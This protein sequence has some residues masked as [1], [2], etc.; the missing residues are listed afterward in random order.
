MTYRQHIYQLAREHNVEVREHASRLD[1][2]YAQTELRYLYVPP[3][4]SQLTYMAALH[5]LGHLASGH[6]GSAILPPRDILRQEGEAWQ[7]ALAHTMTRRI[8]P[9]VARRM[10]G[11]LRTYERAFRVPLEPAAYAESA[12]ALTRL[13]NGTPDPE[14]QLSL[15]A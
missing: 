2:S 5:E 15:F 3:I 1:D 6:V 13:A 7:W 9:A 8:Q 12:A 10:L 14:P 11:Y 4:N